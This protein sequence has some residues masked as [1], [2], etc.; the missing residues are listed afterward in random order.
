MASPRTAAPF[1]AAFLSTLAAQ[2]PVWLLGG[3][4]W[5]VF[6]MA[7]V[8]APAVGALMGG[9]AWGV[10]MWATVGSLLAA[11]LAWRRSATF[12]V[13]DRPS[14]RTAIDEACRKSRLVVLAE[15]CD[16]LVLGPK[17]TLVRFRLQEAVVAFDGDTA[18]LTASAISLPSIRKQLRKALAAAGTAPDGRG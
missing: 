8:G 2:F 10:C 17:R 16:E 6:M 4:L 12:P 15:S 1:A 5:A 14:F 7:V 11:G 9:I 3:V 18:T 13:G